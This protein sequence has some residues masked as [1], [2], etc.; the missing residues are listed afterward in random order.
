MDTQTK[1]NKSETKRPVSV[2][3]GIGLQKK[4]SKKTIPQV[5]ANEAEDKQLRTMHQIRDE[6][7]ELENKNAS[8]RQAFLG[9][10]LARC[11]ATF[12]NPVEVIGEDCSAKVVPT[13]RYSP[14][15]LGKDEHSALFSQI[16]RLGFGDHFAEQ[17]TIKVESSKIPVERHAEVAQKVAQ[18]FDSLGL[19]SAV[20]Y[21]SGFLPKAG[22]HDARPAVLGVDGNAKLQAIYP[23]VIQVKLS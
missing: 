23:A 4:S 14:L 1:T 16:E 5:V 20:S 18:L 13:N 11:W 22:F 19:A 6:V 2:L 9:S 15:D 8:T 12:P 10:V 3:A 21:T 7:A 17:F